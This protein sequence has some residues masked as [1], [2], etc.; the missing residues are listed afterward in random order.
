MLIKLRN[1]VWK[2]FKKPHWRNEESFKVSN[3]GRVI[4]YKKNPEGEILKVSSLAKYDVFY[5]RKKVGKYDLIYV[6]RA[7]AE[8]FLDNPENKKFVTHID[9]DKRNNRAE[10]L[11]FAN[12][13]ELTAHNMKN[14]AVIAAKEKTKIK[15]RY[16]KLNAGRVKLIKRKIFDPNRKTRMRLIAKQFGISEMQ[17]YRIK[18]GENWGHVEYE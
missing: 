7:V 8:L 3:F 18:S 2:D 10:N 15:P 13:A 12:R 1:E 4:T 11:M 17:L 14:P 9:F 6:H 5:A 16:S